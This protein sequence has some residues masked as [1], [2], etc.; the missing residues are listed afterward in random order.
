MTY[1]D[2]AKLPVYYLGEGP[3][4]QFLFGNGSPAA[5]DVFNTLPDAVKRF[6]TR[7]DTGGSSMQYSGAWAEG[8]NHALEKKP[9][10][11]LAWKLQPTS[12]TEYGLGYLRGLLV[13]ASA[14]P[15][16]APR[17]KPELAP[18]IPVIQVAPVLTEPK[19]KRGRPRKK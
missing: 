1:A 12:K 13:L 14:K 11:P 18:A 3:A 17:V 10:A 15:V 6:G 7:I 8:Q 4:G 9:Y 5:T 16:V 19:K 2:I